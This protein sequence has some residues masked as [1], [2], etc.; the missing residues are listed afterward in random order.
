MV[1]VSDFSVGSFNYLTLTERVITPFYVY[2][3]EK[4]VFQY[5]AL[6]KEIT[7][8]LEKEI[9]IRYAVKANSNL[10]I[11]SLL[12][13][14][15]SG[16]EVVSGGELLRALKAKIP[17]NRIVFSGIGKTE[18]EIRLAIDTGV[19]QLSVESLEELKKVEEIA[20]EVQKEIPIC[21]RINPNIQA[22]THEKITTGTSENKF[23]IPLSQIEEASK[24]IT[25]SSH[26]TYLGLSVH[27]GSQIQSALSYQKTFKVIREIVQDLKVKG[28]SFRRLDLG[29]G[30]SVPYSIDEHPFDITA[31][32]KALKEELGDLPYDFVIEPGRYLVA[33]AGFL[34]TKVLYIKRT[35]LRTFVVIDAGMNDMMRSALYDAK[36]SVIP[37]RASTNSTEEELVDLVGPVCES[38]DCF[39][40]Q[41][42][43]PKNLRPGD[44]LAITHAGAYG[45]SLSSTYNTRALIPEVLVDKDKIFLIRERIEPEHFL[46]FETP[47]HL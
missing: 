29:G 34:L 19:E 46:T 42:P 40:K 1:T 35:P 45:A 41:I 13:K 11:L 33:E 25:K 28:Y 17:A 16:V 14:L 27:I 22:Q 12:R 23:G 30:F 6:S 5:Q 24:L 2:D 21:L 44:I 36:H 9:Q 47:R 7:K 38:S 10:A 43:M 15:G 18:E 3:S 31:Y 37:C 20:K 4:I 8:I 39:A 32:A 26:L